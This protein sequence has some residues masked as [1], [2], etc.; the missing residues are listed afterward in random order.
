M[1]S[2]SFSVVVAVLSKLG[3]SP[4]RVYRSG[5]RGKLVVPRQTGIPVHGATGPV[6]G[7]PSKQHLA[8][9]LGC[10]GTEWL[11]DDDDAGLASSAPHHEKMSAPHRLDIDE[12]G[13]GG[14]LARTLT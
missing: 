3:L 5:C 2:S 1:V 8:A 13:E 4:G 11:H 7:I 14:Q 6:R 9:D 10:D 12:G